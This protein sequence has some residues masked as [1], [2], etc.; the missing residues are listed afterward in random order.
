MYISLVDLDFNPA[1][2]PVEQVTP[3]VTCTNRDLVSQLEWRKQ[4]GELDGE[5]LPEVQ[6]RCIT[7]PSAPVRSELRGSLEWRLLSHLS[8]NHLSILQAGGLEALQEILRLYVFT[9]DEEIRRRIV[10]I[11]GLKSEPDVS[12]SIGI[13]Q[14]LTL[15]ATGGTARAM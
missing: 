15:E 3:Y 14:M 1:A 12:P 7:S 2:P 9:D 4:W 10:G 8:L 5:G 6:I 11:T 13:M